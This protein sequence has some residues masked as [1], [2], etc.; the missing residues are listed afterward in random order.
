VSEDPTRTYPTAVAVKMGSSGSGLGPETRNP[1]AALPRGSSVAS[2][3]AEVGECGPSRTR[4]CNLRI[5]SPVLYHLSYRP[6][7][8]MKMGWMMG[9][10]PTTSGTTIRRSNQLSYTHRVRPTF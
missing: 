7:F 2:E 3:E 9:F 1:E 5:K 8:T 4:T 6:V 10:E